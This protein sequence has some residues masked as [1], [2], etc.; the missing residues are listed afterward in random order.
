MGLSGRRLRFREVLAPS[1]VA[2]GPAAQHACQSRSCACVLELGVHGGHLAA[3]PR[4]QAA[5]ALPKQPRPVPTPCLPAPSQRPAGPSRPSGTSQPS[6]AASSCPTGRPAWCWSGPGSPSRTCWL[7]CV[8][9]TASTGL[10]WTSSWRA[11]TRCGCRD[12]GPFSGGC[13]SCGGPADGGPA[14]PRLSTSPLLEAWPGARPGCE[15]PWQ[16]AFSGLRSGAVLPVAACPA[17]ADSAW[18]HEF[19]GAAREAP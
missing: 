1:R 16:A 10:P 13:L 8:S 12:L 19:P 7:G 11:G 2:G 18:R 6:T 14:R 17:P 4:V 5:P 15:L 9:G 3:P